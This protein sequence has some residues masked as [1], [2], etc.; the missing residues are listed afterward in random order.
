[1]RKPILS[2]AEAVELIPDAGALVV[3]GSGGG[4]LEPDLLLR[5]LR[6]RYLAT[7]H[8]RD[9]TLV[10]CT[11]I[12]DKA[13]GGLGVLAHDG[14]IRRVVA[15]N[16][17]M[18]PA[19][20]QMALEGRF[21][22]Y[23]FPQ[24]VMSQL[25]REIAAGRPG[26]ITHVGLH[27]FVDPRYEGGK[28][29]DITREDLVE[30]I[31]I[32]GR[33]WLLY[34][35]FPIDVAFIRGTVIDEEG[36]LN[37]EDEAARLEV[38]A[39]AQAAHNAG[40]KVIAQAKRLA[41]AGS[42]PPQS[43]VVPGFLVDAIVLHPGQW[44]TVEGEYNPS[45][46]GRVKVPL[47]Q[48]APLPLNERKV[49]ARRAYLEIPAGAV[50]NLGVGMADGVAAVAAE[51]GF[52]DKITLTIEQGV[53]GGIPA[54]GVIFGV[55]H[56]PTAFVDQPYQ[57]DFYD[58]GGLDV[59]CLGCGEV[60]PEGNVNVSKFGDKLIGTGGFVN[61]SQN[62]KKVV[63]CSTFTAGG[64]EVDIV[65]GEVRI[66]R[67]GRFRKF[68]GAIEQVTFNARYGLSKGQ[69]ILYVT[70]RAVFAAT[71]EGLLLREMAP[72]V[73]LQ[74]DILDQMDFRPLLP[75]GQP[76]LMDSRLFQPGLL[77]AEQI[78]DVLAGAGDGRV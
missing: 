6:D 54:K 1:M 7:G 27:T 34:R 40:G 61:I 76:E 16:W 4:L 55:S 67:E 60:D 37:L 33:E 44:Q 29:N 74:R 48:V 58:G 71:S 14:L 13:D 62:A 57:F 46:S 43:V 9:L 10:H 26:L 64:L 73:D 2:A 21:E 72:G 52:S 66:V 45:F 75:A 65:D 18:A 69:E 5:G 3:E 50:V 15:G 41:V 11:G 17:A 70:E 78:A 23:N 77:A 49:V 38:L 36:N 22:A 35:T 59:T 53:V 63:F 28:L 47:H 32:H 12:G 42:L 24:G 19:M 31:T 8:P 30:L 25:F 68:R 56:N 51:E 39:I 20:G